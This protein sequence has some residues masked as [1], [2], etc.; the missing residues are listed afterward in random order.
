MHCLWERE[1]KAGPPLQ[2]LDGRAENSPSARLFQQ[3]YMTAES[4][5]GKALRR[6][7][8]IVR[9]VFFTMSDYLLNSCVQR[10]ISKKADE[11]FLYNLSL[12]TYIFIL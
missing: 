10:K 5:A 2:L 7:R 12:E 4:G 11:I 8:N 1:E 6:E 9:S 3:L